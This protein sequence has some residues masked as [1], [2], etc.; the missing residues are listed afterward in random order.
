MP[1]AAYTAPYFLAKA[2]TT[3]SSSA[4]SIV[5]L[6]VIVAL[7]FLMYR[8]FMKPRQRAAQMQ[9]DTILTLE[10]GD[11]VLTGAGIIGTIQH[12]SGDRVTLWTG[13]GHTVTVLRRT[14][15]RKVE[16]DE[17]DHEP[18]GDHSDSHPWDEDEEDGTDDQDHAELEHDP[19]DDDHDAS[20][21]V[22]AGPATGSVDSDEPDGDESPDTPRSTAG[23][24]FGTGTVGADVGTGTIGSDEGTGTIGSDSSS[25]TDPSSDPDASSNGTAERTQGGRVGPGPTSDPEDQQQ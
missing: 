15:V 16:G 21:G 23:G 2:S 10:P 19:V 13:A 20:T 17:F 9:R 8:F 6:F 11:E 14:I 4:G 18:G 5:F 22:G 7:F 12:I 3:P 1:S 24:D 25:S